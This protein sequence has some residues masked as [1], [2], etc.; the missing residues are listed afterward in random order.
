[1]TADFFQELTTVLERT[2]DQHSAAT[3]GKRLIAMCRS[4]RGWATTHPREFGWV[5]ARPARSSDAQPATLPRL[6]A[7]QDFER[8]FLDEFVELWERDGF[9]VPD[10]DLLAPALRKQVET[11]ASTTSAPLPS[12]AVH[13]FLTCWI[14]LYG[15]LCMEVFGQLHFAFSDVEP[16]FE[17]CL[18]DICGML[19]I[20]YEPPAPAR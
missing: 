19:D 11:Y 18:R 1:M 5:F 17:E 3:P 15:L 13:V 9:P 8:L 2:K 20:P 14:R 10:V 7:G 4:M 6:R 16:V 12:D